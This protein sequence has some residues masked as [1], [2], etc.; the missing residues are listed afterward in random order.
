VTFLRVAT[1]TP[2]SYPHAI[3]GTIFFVVQKKSQSHNSDLPSYIETLVPTLFNKIVVP[4]AIPGPKTQFLCSREVVHVVAMIINAVV[5]AADV[6]AQSSFYNQLFDLYFNNRPSTLI[7][8]NNVEVQ[9][10][11]QPFLPDTDD[12][13]AETVQLFVWAVAAARGD[14]PFLIIS[15]T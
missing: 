4:A 14:V 7:S 12:A 10:N 2:V 3:L 8:S 15:L 11:F 13:Q 6:L 1:A 5:R 9:D